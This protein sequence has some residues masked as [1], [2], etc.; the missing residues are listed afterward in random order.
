MGTKA[1]KS[2][3]F[4]AEKQLLD[5]NMAKGVPGAVGLL[6]ISS[7]DLP[8]SE[9]ELRR[10][11]DASERDCGD[12]VGK[13]WKISRCPGLFSLSGVYEPRFSFKN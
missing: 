6:N 7:S 9:F 11:R 2:G 12:R 13:G 4:L 1:W 5:G 8:C 3:F 10:P